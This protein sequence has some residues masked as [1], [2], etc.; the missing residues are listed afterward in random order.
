MANQ[1]EIIA[2]LDVGTTKVAVV[3]GEVK[4]DGI[5]ITG[6]GEQP[7]RGIKRGDVVNIDQTVDSIKQA[8]KAAE[9]I[10][11]CEIKSVYVGVSGGHIKG[12]N[13]SGVVGVKNKHQGISKE[14]VDRVLEAARAV[15]I[16]M[17]REI[18]H[19]IPQEF[20]VDA[21]G[22]GIKDPIGMSG[23]RLEARVHIVTAAITNIQ[24]LIKCIQ[25]AG[26]NVEGLILEVIASGESCLHEDEKELGVALVDIGGGTS[27]IAVYIDGSVV[28]TSVLTVGGQHLDNDISIGLRTPISEAQRLKLKYGCALIDKVDPEEIIE[29][30]GIGGRTPRNIER[31][32]LT[33]IIE[34][35]LEEVFSLVKKSLVESS[36]IDLLTSGVVI[37]GGTTMMDSITELGERVLGIPVR[38]GSPIH[39]GGLVDMVKDPR[40]STGVG[41]VMY[42]S[43]HEGERRTGKT[44]NDDQHG[45]KKIWKKVKKWVVE[46]F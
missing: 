25:R 23:V 34:P 30:S 27:D 13:S 42:G 12:L 17:D 31:Q 29:I 45:D 37:T 24:N 6:V 28:H 26:L 10:S 40:Y 44:K 5:D 9:S 43:K 19:V 41:L 22:G 33:K 46:A 36:L 11:G 2:G 8:V 39:I 20:V 15:A 35:R 3:V 32:V 1:G 14:D 21:I 7:S 4:E 38:R 18:I 16:P